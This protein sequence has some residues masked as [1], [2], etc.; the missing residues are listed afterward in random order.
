MS[1]HPSY[2]A[3]IE[4]FHRMRRRA[5]MQ[6]I[7]NRFRKHT[8]LLSYEDIRQQLRA[9]EKSGSKLQ[10]IPLDAI[11]GSVGRYTDFTRDFLPTK[12][13]D[14]QRWA[15][16][17]TQIYAQEGLPPIEVYQIGQVYFVLD[18]N[19]R[20]SVA[21]E[22][23]NQ[24]IEAY[25]REVATNVSLDV[26]ENPDQLLIKAEFAE[27][28]EQTRFHQL[29][30][31]IDLMVTTPG[32][33]TILSQ[34]IEAIHFAREFNANEDIPY[35][36]A[37]RYWYDTVYYPIV[38]TIRE[39]NILE[40]YPDRTETDLFLW[41]FRHRATLAKTLG[42]DISPNSAAKNLTQPSSKLRRVY[43]Q[44]KNLLLKII[45][46]REYDSGPPPGTWRQQKMAVPEGRLFANIIVVIDGSEN[47]WAGFSQCA[48][49][50]GL[51]GS[52]IYGLHITR[53]NQRIS[54]QEQQEI[55]TEFGKRCEAYD[56]RGQLAFDTGP[57]DLILRERACWADLVVISIPE[58]RTSGI[59][60]LVQSCPA[61]LLVKKGHQPE[62]KS[63]L[64]VYDGS[65]KSEE[66]LFLAAYMAT[67]WELLLT[68]ITIQQKEHDQITSGT[69][70]HAK[71][72]LDYY[73]VSAEYKETAHNPAES[74]LKTAID[75]GNDLILTGGYCTSP[76]TR[77][78]KNILNEL[79][80]KSQHSIL[81][82]R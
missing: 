39:Q 25:V 69:M 51:E 72:F 64:L 59:Q 58:K 35:D 80:E 9:I 41:I 67:F 23:G 74:I 75:N 54:S 11:Q 52:Q 81:I 46:G 6:K 42:W 22:M 3:A 65:P 68:V 49:I 62:F 53:S 10:T 57:L 5:G 21:R 45:R 56:L 19:H 48:F 29:Y 7:F 78:N 43:N 40:E 16:V 2:R 15:R 8:S 82:C 12:S 31:D 50:A 34:Q 60:S 73:G 44:S 66:A 24:T 79:L 13:I 61:P 37:V 1:L 63:I 47:G 20:V 32:S 18:G 27:F 30:P 38:E 55:Q 70:I 4:D 26:D 28:L 76:K 14:P 77:A 36:E 17:K 33:Y 71:E